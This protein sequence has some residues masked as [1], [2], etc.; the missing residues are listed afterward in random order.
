[1]R[2]IN[3]SDPENPFE[4]GFYD[5]PGE[6][7]GVA[8]A[9][10]LAYLA[11]HGS[12]LRIVDVSDPSTPAEI[13]FY[14]MTGSIYSCAVSDTFVYVADRSALHVLNVS[15][16]SSPYEAGTF[17]A[18]GYGIALSDSFAYVAGSDGRVYV[19][20]VSDPTNPV[21]EGF[22]RTP[23]NTYSVTV[24]HPYIYVACMG[25]GLQI[26]EHLPSAG[27]E[28]EVNPS[29]GLRLELLQNSPNPFKES[30][31]TTIVYSIPRKG[32]V[33]LAMYNGLGQRV[34]TLVSTIQQRGVHRL[35]WR[36]ESDSGEQLSPGVYFCRVESGDFSDTR[37]IL[38]LD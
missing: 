12:G 20:D 28:E 1:M 22:Y 29:Q 24:S 8:V 35:V 18:G 19:V 16:P 21:E 23:T 2:V 36:G 30:E 37:K 7:Y 27:I 31:G 3:V 10:T 33:D 15:D 5:T 14:D 9:E 11:D 38:L 32:V 26:Y 4:V 17:G 34:K 6:V 25:T 13:G